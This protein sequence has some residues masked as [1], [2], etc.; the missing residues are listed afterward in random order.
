MKARLEA[1]CPSYFAIK[2]GELVGEWQGAGVEGGRP[3]GEAEGRRGTGSVNSELK[4]S[5]AQ[6]D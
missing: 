5:S 3:K 2:W 1:Q 4:G 6:R